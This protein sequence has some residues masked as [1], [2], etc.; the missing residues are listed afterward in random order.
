MSALQTVPGTENLAA[1]VG[2]SLNEGFFRGDYL[3]KLASTTTSILLMA[4]PQKAG[5]NSTPF[6]KT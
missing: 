5:L 1:E 6:H 4:L 2:P 3:T